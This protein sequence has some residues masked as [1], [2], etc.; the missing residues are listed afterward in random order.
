[1][2][3]LKTEKEQIFNLKSDMNFL[4]KAMIRFHGNY[5]SFTSYSWLHR[6]SLV[7]V[8]HANVPV[9]VSNNGCLLELCAR[10]DS[11]RALPGSSGKIAISNC[12][13]FQNTHR[14]IRKFRFNSAAWPLGPHRKLFLRVFS[15]HSHFINIYK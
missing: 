1:M 13:R 6:E 14:T 8:L 7:T 12:S 5:F 11:A 2:N 4:V 3:R 10:Q 9:I 15:D